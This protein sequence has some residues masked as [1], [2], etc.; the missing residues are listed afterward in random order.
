MSPP[1]LLFLRLSH[2]S[3]GMILYPFTIL[4][5]LKE[6]ALD[7]CSIIKVAQLKLVSII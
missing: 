4:I 1:S 7:I 5:V 6:N 3:F 2:L